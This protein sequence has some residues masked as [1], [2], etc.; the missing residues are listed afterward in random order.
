MHC[1]TSPTP[2]PTP[3][4][5]ST[6]RRNIAA[7]LA[8]MAAATQVGCGREFFREWA[9]QDVS[10]TIFE[11]SRDPRFRIDMFSIDPP[12]MSRYADPYDPDR[13]PAPPDDLATQALSPVPQ[14]PDNRL[15]VPLEGTGYLAMLEEYQPEN[16]ARQQ[17]LNASNEPGAG[18]TP[19]FGRGETGP[20]PTPAPPPPMAPSPF[21]PSATGRPSGSVAPTS[22]APG[23]RAS[24]P[25]PAANFGTGVG[26]LTPLDGPGSLPTPPN[27]APSAS[28]RPA[29][30]SAA[31]V[32]RKTDNGVRLTA[33]QIP[34]TPSIPPTAEPRRIPVD[35]PAS[36]A[37]DPLRTPGIPGDTTPREMQDLSK[38]ILPRS[39]LSPMEN[40]EAEAAG[41]ELLGLL[42]SGIVDFDENQAIGL[43]RATRPYIVNMGQAL[44]LGLINARIYQFQ[45]ENL[46]LTALPVTLNRFA[47]S[48]QFI[49]GLSPT[50]GTVG[51]GGSP[52]LGPVVNPGTI[53]NYRTRATGLQQSNLSLGTVAAVG[54]N[55]D[56]GV[57]I[58]GSFASQIV[59]NFT[60]RNPSQPTVN[61]FLPLNVFV[62]F[63]R[64]GGR[65]LTLEPLTQAERNLVYQIRSFAKFRQEFLITTLVGGSFANFATGVVTPGFSGGGNSDPT[66]G[67][68]NVLE[69][70]IIVE[71]QTRNVQT[72]S[73]F[74]EVYKELIKGESSGVTQ[75]QLDQLD[76]NLQQARSGLLGFRNTLRFDLDAFKQ[77]LGLPPDTPLTVDRT[78]TQPFKQVFQDVEVWARD[79]KRNLAQLE[80]IASKLPQLQDVTIDGR[81]ATDLFRSQSDENLE[82][83]LLASER[84]SFENRLD[85]M[86]LRAN[87]YDAWR[88]IRVTANALKGVFNVNLTNQFITPPTTTNPFGFVSQAKQ[89]SLVLNAELPLVRLAERNNFRT[90]LI[91]YQRQRR[92]LQSAEDY[93]KLQLRTDVRNL[94]VNYLNYEL[95]KR[96][97]VLYARQKDQSFENIVAP[98]QGGGTGTA[99]GNAG[100]AIQTQNLIGAQNALIQFENQLVTQWYQYQVNRLIL[101]RDLGT[102]PYDEWEA[103]YELFPAQYAGV[104]VGGDGVAGGVAD[105]PAVA[106]PSAVNRP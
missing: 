31:Q 4:P 95:T 21:S 55:F 2:V 92:S 60:G 11:K 102:L 50:T 36:P 105:G 45:L 53:F 104:G 61:S 5:R 30:G 51:P 73:Q 98:P 8:F 85:L 87:L 64:G 24:S 6:T 100:G 79:P 78:L 52:G 43:P 67:F 91:N 65:A 16:Y 18:R 88:Q 49:A 7:L 42:G 38:P 97:F 96:N 101:Y 99:A 25:V 40:Q 17:A 74:S 26:R 39:D 84:V 23:V 66:T 19:A 9:N 69:D 22:L 32:V 14:W 33:M 12:A 103:F 71:N 89:F 46:Y 28:A 54:K 58:L 57:K 106:S 20:T 62:P 93:Q 59:F 82:D 63:L 27:P 3:M 80:Q 44:T 72:L 83:L 86:N 56:N 77:Q 81:S 47:F 13:P 29:N 68:L 41:A 15:M 35:A 70:F 48:P 94:Q 34:A 76:S 1:R 10:E 90:A 75:L 37:N